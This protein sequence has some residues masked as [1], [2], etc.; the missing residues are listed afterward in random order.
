MAADAKDEEHDV[1][2]ED[3]LRARVDFEAKRVTRQFGIGATRAAIKRMAG[4]G[5]LRVDEVPAVKLPALLAE[6]QAL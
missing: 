5:V 3:T 4:N 1:E 6:L 2:D